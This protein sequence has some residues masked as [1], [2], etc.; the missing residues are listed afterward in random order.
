MRSAKWAMVFWLGGAMSAMSEGVSDGLG[1]GVLQAG[2]AQQFEIHRTNRLLIPPQHLD[3]TAGPFSLDLPP[4]KCSGSDRAVLLRVMP[5]VATDAIVEQ[6]HD[7]AFDIASGGSFDSLFPPASGYAAHPDVAQTQLW[8]SL[9]EPDGS[10]WPYSY[11]IDHRFA[12][13][14][15]SGDRIEVAEILDPATGADWLAEGRPFLMMI[16][17]MACDGS[18]HHLELDL[19]TVQFGRSGA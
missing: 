18:P 7:I 2:V 16:G 3:L 8:V 13:Q 11:F 4:S 10:E 15:A 1:L 14:A 5:A 6:V 17:R 19:I 12:T 9:A